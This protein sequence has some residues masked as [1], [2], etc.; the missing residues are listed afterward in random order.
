MTRRKHPKLPN[1]YGSIKKLSGN[2]RNPYG[3]YPPTTEFSPTGSPKTP[4]ALCYVRDWYTG[5]QAL[6]EYRLGTFD[7]ANYSGAVIRKPQEAIDE[8]I[9]SYNRSIRLASTQLTFAD[10]YEAYF[11]DKYVLNQTRKYSS[12]SIYSTR[13]AFRYCQS[14]HNKPFRQLKTADLQRVVDDCPKKHAT[15]EHICNLYNQMYDYADAHDLCDKR[16]SDYVKINTPE[17][18]VPG[19]PFTEAEIHTLWEHQAGNMTIQ[20][21]LIMIYSGFRI[22]AYRNLKI[23]M[24]NQYFQGGVKTVAGKDRIVPFN[25]LIIPLINPDLELFQVTKETFR[26][27]FSSA[28]LELGI[29]GHTPHDCRHTFSWLCDK[30]GVD[31]LSKRI[32]LGHSLGNDVTDLK[33]GHRTIEE[34]RTEIN[35]IIL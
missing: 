30:Y 28:L 6:M 10:V 19:I 15:K 25:R 7:P 13:S 9:A 8:I 26:K 1:G 35:K 24:V 20:G 4:P 16:Y 33:Y 32:M 12:S 22:A 2:R 29:A 14:L 5:F 18:D 23:D 3:V 11:H 27:R 17:D 31:N 34:L 21:I